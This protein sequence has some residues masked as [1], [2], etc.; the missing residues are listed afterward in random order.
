SVVLLWVIVVALFVFFSKGLGFGN[1]I[2]VYDGSSDEIFSAEERFHKTWGAENELAMFVAGGDGLEKA[3]EINEEASRQI[4]ESFGEEKFASIAGLYPSVETR[5]NNLFRW[6]AYWKNGNEEKLK[7][8]L[9]KQGAEFGYSKDAFSP[10]FETLYASHVE[11]EAD[12][13]PKLISHVKQ[14]FLQGTESGYYAITYFVDNKLLV[15]KARKISEGMKDTFIISRN[16]M[17]K[18]ISV[19][20][21]EEVRKLALIAGLL[22]VLLTAALMRN[23]RLTILSLLPVLTSVLVFFGSFSL[24]GF[25]INAPSLIA[26]LV[27]V[28]LCIDYGV[29]MVYDCKYNLEAGTLLAVTLSAVTTIAGGSVLLLATHPVLFYVGITMAI[30]IFSGYIAAVFVVPSCYRLWIVH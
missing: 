14:R 2:R 10:F 6:E 24:L 21:Y 5:K 23:I 1:D 18:A 8:L 15:D 30:G 13:A 20:V 3:L 9:Q 4:E 17:A 25:S 16:N 7:T 26:I 28:G 22:I 12:N 19:S 27:V 11:E 29:F